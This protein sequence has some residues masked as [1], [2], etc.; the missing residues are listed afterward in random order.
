[1]EPSVSVCRKLTSALSSA[2]ERPS[3]PTRL[4]L[5]LSVAD[6]LRGRVSSQRARLPAGRPLRVDLRHPIDP[7]ER[8]PCD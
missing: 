3:R 2:A 6:F 1:M 4:V 7:P 5:M 8:E